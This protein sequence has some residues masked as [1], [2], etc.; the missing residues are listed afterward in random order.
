M[1]LFVSS[2]RIPF[3]QVCARLTHARA[4][5]CVHALARKRLPVY[6][7]SEYVRV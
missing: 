1:F 2:V 4:L 7:T 5:C 3:P 6:G